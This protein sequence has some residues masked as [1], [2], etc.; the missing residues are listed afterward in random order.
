MIRPWES[1]CANVT[2]K[3]F[4][5]RM[6]PLVSCQLIWPGKLPTTIRPRA[7]IW[8]LSS[9]GSDM[10]LQLRGY[11]MIQV[12]NKQPNLPDFNWVGYLRCNNTMLKKSFLKVLVIRFFYSS[13][14]GKFSQIISSM[15]QC[16]KSRLKKKF[17]A[18]K[19]FCLL[20]CMGP[21][22]CLLP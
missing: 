10:C 3:R 19:C 6:F 20:V 9:M 11:K 16:S 14:K 7:S 13:I 21:F 12:Y 22:R 15:G 2:S 5:T 8:L 18:K 4:D 1:S 17:N